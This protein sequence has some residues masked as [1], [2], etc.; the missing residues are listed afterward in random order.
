MD[1]QADDCSGMRQSVP[2]EPVKIV[3]YRSMSDKRH[4]KRN[5]WAISSAAKEQAATCPRHMQESTPE[6]GAAIFGTFQGNSSHGLPDRHLNPPGR[7]L[8]TAITGGHSRSTACSTPCRGPRPAA[9][10]ATS[11]D[12]ELRGPCVAARYA[13][14][15]APSINP[16]SRCQPCLKTF[17]FPRK[18]FCWIGRETREFSRDSYYFSNHLGHGP[19][20]CV[21][22]FQGPN[23][24]IVPGRTDGILRGSMK[25]LPASTRGIYPGARTPSRFL[26][27]RLLRGRVLLPRGRK[28][29]S[30]Y[31]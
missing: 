22:S 16:D 2:S 11:G 26:S 15:W 5:H 31:I 13:I 20:P 6:D 17:R 10:P 28:S 14:P 21:I 9:S 23:F 18:K 7:L 25:R 4:G 12:E 1:A 30:I 27:N 8:G 24:L 19:A 29:K 3:A